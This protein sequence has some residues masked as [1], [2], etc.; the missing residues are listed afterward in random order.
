ML[1]AQVSEASI[2]FALMYTADHILPVLPIK[3]LV[4]KDG[5]LTMPFKLATGRKPSVSHLRILF[6]PCV[7]RKSTAHVCTKL[8]NMRH[9]A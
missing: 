7:V 1:H 6:F 5:E 8:L 3:E 9:Q 4:N 2:H